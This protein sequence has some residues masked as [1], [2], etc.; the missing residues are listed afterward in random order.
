MTTPSEEPTPSDLR[1]LLSARCLLLDFDGPICRL[2]FRHR[3]DRI[4]LAMH[5]RLAHRGLRITDE[6]LAATRDPHAILYC[7]G[8]KA[9]IARV[10]SGTEPP[11]TG[12]PGADGRPE[13]GADPGLILELE[14]LLTREE[15]VAARSAE[16]T[17]YAAEFVRAAAGNGKLLAVTTNNSPGSVRTYLRNHHLEEP[18]GDRIFGRDPED[19]SRM[20]PDPD[21]LLRAIDALDA[22]PRE[23]LM[24]GDSASDAEAATAA[25]AGFL[26]FAHT[27]ER[28][29]RLRRAEPHPVVVGMA[30]LAA[31]ARV[32]DPPVAAR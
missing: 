18:F 21:C 32:L 19:P 1:G 7:L 26:G 5:D 22:D 10:A 31:A 8:P 4:A 29:A 15:D 6:R 17:P 14:E 24:I 25:G 3:A 20:K 11:G 30:S 13:P 27:P 28:V 23:C 12:P 9:P 16:P 2:F